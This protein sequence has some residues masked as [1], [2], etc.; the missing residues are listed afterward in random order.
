MSK[1]SVAREDDQRLF[2]KLIKQQR[3]SNV[4]GMVLRINV[5]VTSDFEAMSKA[6][7]EHFRHLATPTEDESSD[8]DRLLELY[9]HSCS[10]NLLPTKKLDIMAEDILKMIKSLKSG[11]APDRDGICT[12]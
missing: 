11:K 1:I 10:L 6:W 4:S 9:R 12:E 5:I 2:Y 3:A 8:I 7:M